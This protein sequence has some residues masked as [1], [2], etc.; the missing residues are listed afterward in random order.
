MT[1]PG[2]GRPVVFGD[3]I[4]QQYL[5]AVAGG[6]RLGP[7]AAHVGVSINIPRRHERTHPDFAAALADAK[8]HGKKLRDDAKDHSEAHYNHDACRHPACLE[9]ARTGR[10]AR[11]QRAA[12]PDPAEVHNMRPKRELPP[13]FPLARAS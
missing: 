3:E 7:A 8:A 1:S 12:E 9:A 4:R 10:A 5:A 2:R 6:M 11:R 13:F